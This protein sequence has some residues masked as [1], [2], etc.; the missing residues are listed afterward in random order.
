MKLKGDVTV[1]DKMYKV[2]EIFLSI[3]GEGVRTGLA[4]V[5]IRLY[6]CNLKCSY[7]DTRYSCENSEYTEMPL[8]DI[9]DEHNDE[10]HIFL[11]DVSIKNN[12]EVFV[13]LGS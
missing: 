5:F 13:F 2:N 4:T 8:M 7:C 6:G 12:N 1:E 3:D 9:L 10:S 11:E